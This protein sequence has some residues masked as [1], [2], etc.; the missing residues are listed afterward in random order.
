MTKLSIVLT[1]WT[2]TCGQNIALAQATPVTILRVDL[3]NWV[4]YF[5]DVFDLSKLGTDPNA[6]TAASAKNFRSF[7]GVADIVGVNGKPAKGALVA[8]RAQIFLNTSPTPGQAVADTVRNAIE[9]ASI[10]IL[11]TDGTPVG[12][13]FVNGLAAGFPPPGAPLA[14]TGYN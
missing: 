8:R 12:S 7:I 3:E 13:I 5:Y 6:T 14:S 9:D 2:F 1:L 4:P 11:Q 10:E